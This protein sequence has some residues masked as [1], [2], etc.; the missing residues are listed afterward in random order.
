VRWFITNL[1]LEVLVNSLALRIGKLACSS[2]H[3]SATL[4]HS[5]D[6]PPSSQKRFDWGTSLL[7]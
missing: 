2:R 5:E 3:D 7:Q 1:N 6:G 4:V